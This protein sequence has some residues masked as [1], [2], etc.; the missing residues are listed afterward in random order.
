MGYFS[1]N[2]DGN[3]G[4]PAVFLATP[5]AFVF[6][7]FFFFSFVLFLKINAAVC[8]HSSR[9]QHIL[10]PTPTSP[11]STQLFNKI[12]LIKEMMSQ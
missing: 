12:C 8:L 2:F 1:R 11:F 10:Y 3:F 6:C 5:P 9:H 4:S 7:F